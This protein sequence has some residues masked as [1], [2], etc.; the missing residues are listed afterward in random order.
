MREG[1][2]STTADR[3][4]IERAAHQLLDSPLL[5]ID[6]LALKVIDAE[7]AAALQNHPERHD[8]SPFAKGLRAVVVVRSRVAEDEIARAAAAGV[9][10]YVVLGAGLDTFAYRNPHPTVRVF[11]VD[12][13]VTQRLKRERLA[14]AQIDAAGRV[15]FVPCDLT[16]DPLPAALAAAGFDSARPAVFA[17][18]GVVMYL[19][20]S[21]VMQ[22]FGDIA[23]L[24]PGTAVIFDYAL[25]PDALP[26]FQGMFYRAVLDH[27][28]AVGEPWRSFFEPGPLAADLSRLGFSDIEDLGPDEINSRF[29]SNRRDGLQSTA[30]GRIAVARR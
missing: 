5:L 10:Q 15:S 9:A 27:V 7:Q 16:Q 12:H 11:E 25:P 24:P 18:L 28:A 3:V 6:P 23:S 20:R 4:A 13:P 2:S 30:A 8:V 17:W 26:W 14:A 1:Q 22:I 19:E 29:L 21:Q